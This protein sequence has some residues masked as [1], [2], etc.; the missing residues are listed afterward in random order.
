MK[1]Y[2]APASLLS[3]HVLNAPGATPTP[4]HNQRRVLGAS[5]GAQ[6]LNIRRSHKL[7]WASI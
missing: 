2:F 4:C 1:P 7:W 6:Q 5:P 3:P